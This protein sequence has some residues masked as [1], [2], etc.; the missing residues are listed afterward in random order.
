MRLKSSEEK[1][2]LQPVIIGSPGGMALDR[3]DLSTTSRDQSGFDL[4]MEE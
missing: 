2:R 1:R 3:N 4:K